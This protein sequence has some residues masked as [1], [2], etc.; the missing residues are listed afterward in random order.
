MPTAKRG[1]WRWAATRQ[2][3]WQTPARPVML[4]KALKSEGQ[5]PVQARKLEKLKG[6]TAGGDTFKA[7]ALEWHGKQAPE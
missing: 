6:T 7:V 1:A 2:R 5:D 3:A 4:A